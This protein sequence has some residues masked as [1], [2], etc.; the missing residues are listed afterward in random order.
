MQEKGSHAKMV[1]LCSSFYLSSFIFIY[2][3]CKLE[4]KYIVVNG[5][6]YHKILFNYGYMNCHY[7]SIF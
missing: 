7:K 6:F 1:F 4:L 5:F 3:T 2:R